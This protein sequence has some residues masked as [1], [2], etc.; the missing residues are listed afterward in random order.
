[1][2]KKKNPVI[3]K[4]R[5]AGFKDGYTLGTQHGKDSACLFFADKFDGLDQVPGIGP[6]TLEKVVEH[7]GREYF[8]KVEVK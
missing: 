2:A 5:E 7:F 3:V 1:M 8:V 6:K 4:A